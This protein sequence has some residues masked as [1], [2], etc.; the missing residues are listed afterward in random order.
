MRS[1][2]LTAD[3][4]L[5][6]PFINLNFSLNFFHLLN[7]FFIYNAAKVLIKREFDCFNAPASHF[8]E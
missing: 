6:L 4:G 3:T 7:L 2:V 1:L 5:I 8:S